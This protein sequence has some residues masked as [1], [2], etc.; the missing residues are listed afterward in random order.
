MHKKRLEPLTR[1]LRRVS[2]VSAKVGQLLDRLHVCTIICGNWHYV[3]FV[4]HHDL[5][6]DVIYVRKMST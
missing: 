3:L 4:S 6:Y 2:F 1:I 5:K